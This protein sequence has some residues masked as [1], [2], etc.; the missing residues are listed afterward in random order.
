M[1]SI[2]Q[3]LSVRTC[4][5]H[6]LVHIDTGMPNAKSIIVDRQ[7]KFLLKMRTF[8]NN[9]FITR[10]IDLAIIV[11]TPMGNRIHTLETQVHSRKDNF[12][13]DL[14]QSLR[15]SQSTRRQDYT[16]MNPEL[17][18]SPVLDPKC[19]NFIPEINRISVNRLRLG[20]HHLR[21]ETGRWARIPRDERLCVCGGDIQSESRVLIDCPRSEHLRHNINI[22]PQCLYELFNHR[23][24]YLISEYC[25]TSFY[26]TYLMIYSLP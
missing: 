10:I 14:R 11:K 4:T 16:M 24:T 5:C 3:M 6:D 12:F 18:I 23:S 2:K 21:I 17:N 9:D 7:V 20:S 8:H 25:W 13:T 22:H 1:R 26:C 19:D 15:T